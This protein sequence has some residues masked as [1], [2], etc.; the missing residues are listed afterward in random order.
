MTQHRPESE[1]KK[2]EINIVYNGIAKPIEVHAHQKAK[3]L[4]DHAIR[5]FNIAQNPHLLS[6][7]REDGTRVDESQPIAEAGL[8][9]GMTLHL[10]AD[11][12]KGG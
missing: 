1:S 2:F 8:R 12:V 9:E 11:A 3:V 7:F 5:A 4:L 6:L 10:R